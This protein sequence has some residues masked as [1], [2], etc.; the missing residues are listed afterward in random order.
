GSPDWYPPSPASYAMRFLG[1]DFYLHD[2]PW[3]HVFGPASQ[4]GDGPPGGDTT[5]SH[6][7][8]NL[9][10][11]AARFLYDWAP[12]GT[13]VVVIGAAA[14]APAA[15]APAPTAPP[16]APSPAAAPAAPAATYRVRR[17]D[18]LDGLARRFGVRAAAL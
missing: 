17:G 3:R 18:T 8:V 11:P 7:C 15:S 4:G 10:Y 6:G 9:P 14:P 12:E 13:P 2:A 1:R 16:R 5:G